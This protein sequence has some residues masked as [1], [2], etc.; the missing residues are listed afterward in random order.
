MRS[1][2]ILQS[3]LENHQ[4]WKCSVFFS[5]FFLRRKQQEFIDEEENLS[6]NLLLHSL[7]IFLVNM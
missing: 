3:N 4:Q 7:N 2:L 5:F 1:T 6:Y